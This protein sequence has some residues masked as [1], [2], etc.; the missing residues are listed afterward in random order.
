[1]DQTVRNLESCVNVSKAFKNKE[2]RKIFREKGNTASCT[3]WE[4][5]EH[6]IRRRCWNKPQGSWDKAGQVRTAMF[7]QPLLT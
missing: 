5:S 6:F 4:G 2:E 3:P 1:M 7:G